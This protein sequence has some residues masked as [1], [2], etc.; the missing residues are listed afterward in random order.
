MNN[1]HNCCS[2]ESKPL[3]T[4][5]KPNDNICPSCNQ[6][7]KTV[8]VSAVSHFVNDDVKKH[9]S[10][11]DGFHFCNTPTCDVIYFKKGQILKQSDVK[12]SIGIKENSKPATVCFCF[13]WSKERIEDQIRDSGT[14][15][16]LEE[17]K[18]KV[19]N[20]ACNCEVQNPKGKC[21]MGDVKKAIEDIKIKLS[22]DD[23]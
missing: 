19:K 7:A 16:A 5:I 12:F 4:M 6:K 3:F 17:I 11:L 22:K 21:C 23:K 14:T 15:T 18:E 10:S 13:N 8:P 9:I 1:S 20:K 2:A